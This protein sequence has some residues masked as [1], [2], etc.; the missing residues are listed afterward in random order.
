MKVFIITLFLILLGCSE[1]NIYTKEELY[2]MGIKVDPNLKIV[3]PKDIA[4]G[5]K[6]TSYG[7]GCLRGFEVQHLELSMLF[8]EFESHEQAK[9]FA[10]TINGYVAKNWLIDDVY[11]EP[12]LEDFVKK[13]FGAKLYQREGQ[14]SQKQ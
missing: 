14:G 6:C 12:V 1:E 2:K 3:L 13:A 7:E 10:K 8:V 9:A 5:V 11:G 4:S